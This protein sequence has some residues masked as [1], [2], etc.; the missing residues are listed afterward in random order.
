MTGSGKSLLGVYF[1]YHAHRSLGAKVYSMNNVLKFGHPLDLN[2][3]LK[4]SQELN[5]TILFL[6]EFQTLGSDSL[7]SMSSMNFIMQQLLMQIRK[8]NIV[9][10]A[11]TQNY[12][13]TISARVQY[14][15][16]WVI[17]CKYASEHDI[18][19][20]TA[21]HTG[22]NEIPEGFQKKGRLYKASRYWKHY[23]SFV[24]QDPYAQFNVTSETIRQTQEQE[25]KDKVYQILDHLVKQGYAEMYF[26]DIA[27]VV[28]E[29]NINVTDHKLGRWLKDK[30][31]NPKRTRQGVSYN[32]DPHS[33]DFD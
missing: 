21:T 13:R 12:Y 26:T 8:R 15:V 5:D 33:D 10:I 25:V 24:V 20:F 29:N 7:R 32:I 18:I 9:I 11:N 30:V 3:L 1:S 23:E 19:Y 17:D 14:Q 6:D 2:D 4:L 28:K 27:S 31:G 22:S 16:N